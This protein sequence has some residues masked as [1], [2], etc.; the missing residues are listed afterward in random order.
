MA[1]N[2]SGSLNDSLVV[3]GTDGT[4]YKAAPNRTTT[5]DTFKDAREGLFDDLYGTHVAASAPRA[6]LGDGSGRTA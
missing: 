2:T 4:Y 5:E 6:Y 1:I 3:G